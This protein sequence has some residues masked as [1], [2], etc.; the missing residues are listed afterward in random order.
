[1]A[2]GGNVLETISGNLDMSLDE[3][4]KAICAENIDI[5]SFDCF[6]TLVQRPFFYPTDLFCLMDSYINE[7]VGTT[8]YFVFTDVRM[9]AE[10]L[11]RERLSEKNPDSEDVTLDEIYE[12]VSELCPALDDCLDRIKKIECDLELQYCYGR[13]AGKEL[14]DCATTN[15]KKVIVTTDMYLP[16]SVVSAILSKN[17]YGNVEVYVSNEIGKAKYSGNLF[18]YIQQKENTHKILHIGDNKYA[19]VDC[20]EKSG[21]RAF[22][23]PRAMDLMEG[24]IPEIYSGNSFNKIYKMQHGT[25]SGK[26]LLAH[27]G[28]RC[29]IAVA[30]N[31]IFDNPFVVFAK[32][33]DFNADPSIIGYY[34]LGMH[35]FAIADWLIHC[36][37][38]GGY[39]NLHFMARDGY[40]PYE[41]YKILNTVYK[42]NCKIY[43]THLSRKAVLPLVVQNERCFYTLSSNLLL[44]FITPR[45]FIKIAKYIEN[46]IKI[47]EAEEICKDN[48][49]EFDGSFDTVDRFL[50]FGRIWYK[51]FFSSRK[52]IVY[53]KNI[54]KF[55]KNRFSG[56][57][58]TFDV[59]YSLRCESMLAGNFGYDIT[60]HYIHTNNDSYFGRGRKNS[61]K[62]QRLYKN[63]PFISGI[64]REIFIS[65][66]SPSCIAYEKIDG[67]VNPVFE[68]E[69]VKAIPQ[70]E[71][72]QAAAIE[73][74]RD[75]ADIFSDDLPRLAYNYCDACL[76]FEY[77]LQNP[78]ECDQNLLAGIKYEDDMGLGRNLD[79]VDY[80]NNAICSSGSERVWFE[81]QKKKIIQQYGMPL[82][83]K[84]VMG[85]IDKYFP[86]G[87][88]RRRILKKIGNRILGVK[89]K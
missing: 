66:Q 15:G 12:V 89:K 85:R 45:K 56:K 13:K 78:T 44:D 4:K 77:F 25:V 24:R 27:W 62:I 19:D 74:V 22:W 80:W 29:M 63:T 71:K 17:G 39:D 41:A 36:V 37:K 7:F 79:I 60:A 48:G 33:S 52:A 26:A 64:I 11:A 47:D 54:D 76:P 32:E 70:I 50:D 16:K 59:G 14:F 23:L 67:V 42:C 18:I 55:F 43:Y 73:F 5:I 9:R 81:N 46:E 58:A 8:D 51:N 87:S 57:S 35:I 68:K 84:R 20:A 1:M 10:Q 86:H 65:E 75:M 72:M 38:D 6:D 88:L 30:A 69:T 21:I 3:I 61:V 34:I 31:R 2:Y 40:L 53:K 28:I 49:F 83:V 82:S